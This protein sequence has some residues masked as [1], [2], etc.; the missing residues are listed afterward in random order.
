[1]IKLETVLLFLFEEKISYDEI[2]LFNKYSF[3]SININSINSN[4]NAY[5][6]KGVKI[7]IINDIKK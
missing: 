5:D 4:R 2:M 6:I 3:S 7:W 1:M